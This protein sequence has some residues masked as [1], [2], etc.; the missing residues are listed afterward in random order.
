MRPKLFDEFAA[1]K[2]FRRP[3][4]IW[5]S[6]VGVT[7]A[8]TILLLATTG[9]STGPTETRE[10]SF[11]VTGSSKVVVNS[12]NGNIEVS[13]GPGNEVLVQ[14]TLRDAPRVKYEVSQMGNT[15]T[16][17][18]Q[19]S[20]Q[21]GIFGS[22]GADVSIT[23]PAETDVVLN[24]S[25]GFIELHGLE[26]SGSLKSSNGKIA[27]DSVRG[28]FDGGTSNGLIEANAVEG[29]VIL[30][31][32]NG[33]IDL[34]DV[35]GEFDIE[36]SNGG[37]FFSGNMT[38]GGSNRLVTSNGDVVVELQGEPSV[39]LDAET[40]NGEVSSELPIVATVTRKERLV[41]KIGDGEAELYIRTSN[42]DITIR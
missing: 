1:F 25:N 2:N 27:L 39:V 12:V 41:G 26:G 33:K 19:T 37:V 22:A 14:A 34:R 36:S 4:F 30:K 42:G 40:S 10:N 15:I 7:A 11:I 21:L 9:C 23:A 13:A 38:A 16:V 18:V 28:N 6:L 24:T 5:G 17:D 3:R 31:T 35:H 29:S 20:K 32:S 8:V